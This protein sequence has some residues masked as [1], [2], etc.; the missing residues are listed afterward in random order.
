MLFGGSMQRTKKNHGF[1]LI[2]L[3]VTIAVMAIIATMAAPSFNNM[4][5]SQNLK[6]TAFNMKDTLKEARSRA[7]LNRNDI[8]VCSSMDQTGVAISTAICG[9]N[10]VG[11]S[12][13]SI[14]LQESSVVIANVEKKITVKAASDTYFIFSP[15]GNLTT[16]KTITLCSSV[17]SY[18]L[19]VGI[20]G[21]VDITQGAA[22]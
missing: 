10:L 7:M 17:G 19:T 12:S 6:T 2:E 8:V 13:M 11:Y 21:T 18:I 22:C 14:P 3:M 5:I 4:L 15:R 16:T 1:T 9:A 20:P